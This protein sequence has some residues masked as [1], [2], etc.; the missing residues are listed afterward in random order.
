MP[1]DFDLPQQNQKNVCTQSQRLKKAMGIISRSSL[2][3]DV[4]TKLPPVGTTCP[5]TLIF[6]RPAKKGSS[7]A[8]PASMC[9]RRPYPGS[10]GTAATLLALARRAKA[11]RERERIT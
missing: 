3:S 9:G 10:I 4:A 5:G 1:Q 6:R 11:K 7:D 2:P 8:F